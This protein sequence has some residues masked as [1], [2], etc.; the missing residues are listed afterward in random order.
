MSR[1]EIGRN[2]LFT[3]VAE[4]NYDITCELLRAGVHA[5][6]KDTKSRT[7]LIYLCAQGR[8]TFNKLRAPTGEQPRYEEVVNV[9]L[10]NGLDIEAKGEDARTALHW[11]VARGH[12][13][14]VSILLGRCQPVRARVDTLSRGK[15]TALHIAATKKS[16]QIVD[17]LLECGADPGALSEGN[18]T[19]LH[20]A[21]KHGHIE[22]LRMLL[23]LVDAEAAT[24]NGKTALH[25]AAENG[26]IACVEALLPFCR[27]KRHAK[28]S[29]GKSPWMLAA[30]MHHS[31]I[32]HLLSPFND[33]EHLSPLQKR[34]C[35]DFVALV[36]DV[37]PQK[38]GREKYISSEKVAVYDLLYATKND[39]KHKKQSPMVSVRPKQD[40]VRKGVF[41]WIHLPA[42]NVRLH[43]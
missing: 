18:W 14:L 1:E 15:K 8:E 6:C 38:K 24:D 36:T 31:E 40:S 19:P 39:E 4:G 42:N 43:F 35:Q 32:M 28:D 25:W 41:R 2:C 22:T 34:V 27:L 3:A 37:H 21:A 23:G 9:L 12:E 33:D 11:A 7:A 17:L 26:H 13:E 29:K 20:V 30:K 10:S 5:N 16:A